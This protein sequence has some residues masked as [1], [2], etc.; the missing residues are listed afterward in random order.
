[1]EQE[2]PVQAQEPAVLLQP[3]QQACEELVLPG[4]RLGLA[5]LV[6]AR[7]QLWWQH[8]VQESLVEQC[9]CIGQRCTANSPAP[10]CRA[11]DM[12]PVS[13]AS[14]DSGTHTLGPMTYPKTAFVC[15]YWFL[16]QA[17][18]VAEGG[19]F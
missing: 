1:M 12:G 6:R 13:C 19:Y 16:E 4:H 5:W 11:E 17:S 2:G 8:L 7:V 15:P 14:S 9:G 3:A 18:P 10:T